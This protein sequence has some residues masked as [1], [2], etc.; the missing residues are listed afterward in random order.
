MDVRASQGGSGWTVTGRLLQQKPH[1]DLRVPLRLET[2]AQVVE[3]TV[4]LE[5]AEVPFV[6][7]SDEVPRRLIADPAFDIFRRLDM[8]EIPPTVDRLRGSRSL[9]V[10]STA[11][12]SG[13]M[14]EASQVLLRGL[15]QEDASLVP[16][17]K[18]T[19]ADLMDHD[20]LFLGVPHDAALIPRQ[21]EGLSLKKDRFMID[22]RIFDSP[23]DALFVVLPHPKADHRVVAF[24]LPLSAD[25]GAMAARKIPHY[26]KYSYLAFRGGSNWVRGIWPPRGSPTLYRFDLEDVSR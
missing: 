18:A 1:Y 14:V 15:G 6:I 16:Q 10:I 13:S 17:D 19:P 12:I 23:T 25:A 22:G 20:L 11:G 7:R 26:G 2:A 5:G 21:P 24:F 4:H 9:M 3:K 8:A